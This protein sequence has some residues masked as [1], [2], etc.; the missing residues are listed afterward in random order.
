M[1]QW[2]ERQRFE[3]WLAG[4]GYASS[5]CSPDETSAYCCEETESAWAAWQART[6]LTET[7][8]LPKA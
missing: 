7:L 5:R 2:T 6:E 8:G 1:N 3:S 4:T